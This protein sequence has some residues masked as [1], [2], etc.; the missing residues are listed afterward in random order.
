MFTGDQY[1]I[2]ERGTPDDMEHFGAGSWVSRDNDYD[3]GERLWHGTVVDGGVYFVK[4]AN[5]T[6]KWVD[7]H[8]MTGDIYNAE[9]GPPAKSPKEIDRI[10]ETTP[11]GKDIGSPLSISKGTTKNR[12]AAGEDVWFKFEHKDFTTAE[13]EFD[14]FF[15]ELRH[16]PGDGYVTNHV[17]F[18]IYPFQEQHIWRRGDTDLIT[19]LGAGSDAALDKSTNTHTWIWAGHFVSNTIYFIRVRNDS[20]QDID[21]ELLIRR[22]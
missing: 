9:L 21:Y 11:T 6:N 15:I 1:Q 16:S 5:E 8:L 12:L 14:P 10:F 20:I 19:P 18:E 7:Y 3:T 17:N 4:I 2:W 13:V 22:R